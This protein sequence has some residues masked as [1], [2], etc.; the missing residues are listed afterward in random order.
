M[1]KHTRNQNKFQFA[2]Y[3]LVVN[4]IVIAGL[5]LCKEA[6]GFT[7]W[8][9]AAMAVGS[10]LTARLAWVGGRFSVQWD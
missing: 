2:V 6:Y 1:V 4:A 9:F 7:S 8:Q 5:M 10:A 3:M